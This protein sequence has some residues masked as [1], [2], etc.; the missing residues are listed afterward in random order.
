MVDYQK[1][2][3]RLV[4]W[5]KDQVFDSGLKGTVVGLSGG[6]DS[7]VTAVLCKKAF[8]NST[9]GL[10]MPCYSNSE[11]QAHA[12]MLAEKFDI[13]YKVINLE[14]P[15]DAFQEIVDEGEKLAEDSLVRANLKPRLRMITL[16]YYAG[17][18]NAL[19]VGTDNRSELEVGYFTKYGDGGVDITPLATL[20]KKQV[21]EVAKYLGIPEVIIT[22]QPSAGLWS[23]QTDE[24]EMGITYEQLDHYI[25]TGEAEESV[26]ETVDRLN[27][28]SRHKLKMPP[29]PDFVPE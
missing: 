4:N 29:K 3:E 13:P 10:I 24:A 28:R 19:V 25:L 2:T 1:F 9:L 5:I 7:A 16:Y 20:V 18:N 12:K 8:P 6:I 27:K 17:L 21:R 11:D 26:K 22:K 15:F 14:K 23:N